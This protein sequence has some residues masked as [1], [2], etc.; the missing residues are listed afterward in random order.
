MECGVQG[1]IYRQCCHVERDGGAEVESVLLKGTAM[2]DEHVDFTY[3]S[4]SW[5][6]GF[7]EENE[8]LT[9]LAQGLGG[10]DG[11]EG[12]FFSRPEYQETLEGRPA[13][14]VING[15]D[16]DDVLHGGA[17]NDTINGGAGNDTIYCGDGDDG[18]GPTIAPVTGGS[19][20][21]T[22]YGGAGDDTINGGPNSDG[23]SGGD[24]DDIINGG[25][26]AD[27]LAGNAGD[28]VIHGNGGNDDIAAGRGQDDEM[29]GDAG[30][31]F[32][33][34]TTL[35]PS[36]PNSIRFEGGSGTDKAWLQE[37]WKGTTLLCQTVDLVGNQ[38]VQF[39]RDDVWDW[40]TTPISDPGDVLF[41]YQNPS[42]TGEENN[43]DPYTNCD[44]VIEEFGI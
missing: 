8:P 15:N 14:D 11:M 39:A 30:N 17:G 32:L 2:T 22:I 38:S 12:S 9:A 41:D 16:G 29:Y 36:C 7:W 20:N 33:C 6:L 25:D 4:G 3:S 31:D 28:D 34:G 40:E 1:T 35:G 42:T 24:G 26:G 5:N 44:Q 19:G 13:R 37:N 21:D 23:I 43:S 27:N 10:G 18:T